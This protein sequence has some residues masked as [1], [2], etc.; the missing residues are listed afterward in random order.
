MSNSRRMHGRATPLAA[1]LGLAA[2]GLPAALAAQ[3]CVGSMA[4]AH[5][6][7]VYATGGYFHYRFS[8]DIQGAQYG[9]GA[10]IDFPGPATLEVEGVTRQ[11]ASGATVFAGSA[12]ALIGVHVP[13]VASLCLTAG[14]G[15]TYLHDASSLTSNT[16]LA[17]PIGLRFGT[18]IP[19]GLARLEPYLEPYVLLATTTGTVF[20]VQTSGA[21]VGG[22]A[23]AG[24]TLRTGPLAA[25]IVLRV[26]SIGTS[27]GP[28]PGGDRAVL[29]RLGIT[30]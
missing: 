29:V 5:G 19:L 27:I 28:S 15:A 23:D 13:M 18:G 11:P 30:F 17:A 7:A 25:G 26:A 20:D 6:A 14:A 9:A 12:K 4:P 2:L 10:A 1:V 8:Q 21:A 22:G 24:L 16:T 3:A